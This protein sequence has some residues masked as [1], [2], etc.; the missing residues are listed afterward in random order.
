M[1][2]GHSPAGPNEGIENRRIALALGVWLGAVLGAFLWQQQ[3][4][5]GVPRA[6]WQGDRKVLARMQTVREELEGD[7]DR[8]AWAGEYSLG[9]GYDHASLRVAPGEGYAFTWWGCTGL[10]NQDHGELRERGGQLEL[11]SQFEA[12]EPES[13][14]SGLRTHLIPV[15]WGERRFLIAPDQMLAFGNDVR[16]GARPEIFLKRYWVR[17][18][19][20]RSAALQGEP[21]LPAEFAWVLQAEPIRATVLEVLSLP[22][23]AEFATRAAKALVRLDIGSE[24]GAYSW[25]EL[26]QEDPPPGTSGMAWIQEADASGSTAMLYVTEGDAMPEVGWSFVR[27]P[28]APR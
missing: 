26:Y 10:D 20:D 14:W 25:M 23:K 17:G 28:A 2:Q 19:W 16:S 22:D 27:T 1:S 12:V 18:N 15:A 3:A 7:A 4:P 6:G 21:K 9:D 13:S 24:S 5:R 8:A 11:L